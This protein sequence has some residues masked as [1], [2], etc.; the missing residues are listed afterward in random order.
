VTSHAKCSTALNLTSYVSPA[1]CCNSVNDFFFSFGRWCTILLR[2][3][4]QLDFYIQQGISA[5]TLCGQPL[6]WHYRTCS[7]GHLSYLTHNAQLVQ[8][9]VGGLQLPSPQTLS[10]TKCSITI[11]LCQNTLPASWYREE[12]PMT[13]EK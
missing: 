2:C 8:V 7:D 3:L 4:W 5:S 13:L 6:L 12:C 9:C 10:R 11:K 1:G